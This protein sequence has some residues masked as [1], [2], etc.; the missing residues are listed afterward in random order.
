M[1]GM[2]GMSNNRARHAEEGVPRGDDQGTCLACRA[3]AEEVGLL[4][5]EEWQPP[6]LLLPPRGAP[7]EQP[8]SIHQ[9]R[10]GPLAWDRAEAEEAGLSVEECHWSP[11]GAGIPS[12]C[13]NSRWL[14]PPHGMALEAALEWAAAVVTAAAA[15]LASSPWQ[16]PSLLLPPRGAPSDQPAPNHGSSGGRASAIAPMVRP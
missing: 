6:S 5:V 16:P 14:P 12:R 4:S 11:L 13:S 7:S 3:E 9:P 15:L 8:A 10:G 2:S 1:S